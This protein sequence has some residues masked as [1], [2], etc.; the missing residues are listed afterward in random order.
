[1]K[2]GKNVN[3]HIEQRVMYMIHDDIWWYL[4][5]EI[6]GDLSNAIADT[7]E[8]IMLIANFSVTTLNYNI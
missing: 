6:D 3:Y 5:V 1:M 4:D 8:G 2:L 7:I